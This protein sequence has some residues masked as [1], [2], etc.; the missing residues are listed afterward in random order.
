LLSLNIHKLEIKVAV[1]MEWYI[2]RLCKAIPYDFIRQKNPINFVDFDGKL[3]VESQSGLAEA[4]SGSFPE[5][6]PI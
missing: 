6:S 2:W 4:G 5:S 3:L 1:A